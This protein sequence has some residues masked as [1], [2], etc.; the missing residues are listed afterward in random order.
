MTSL[1]ITGNRKSAASRRA[2]VVFP[3]AGA[4]LTIT[5]GGIAVTTPRSRG[6]G[7]LT[8]RPHAGRRRRRPR[9]SDTGETHSTRTDTIWRATFHEVRRGVAVP[10]IWER[11]RSVSCAC[12]LYSFEYIGCFAIKL[13]TIDTARS[14]RMLVA[15]R[16]S[17]TVGSRD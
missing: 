6:G 9:G 4:P 1:A 5:S 13:M 7:G 15:A 14:Q 3:A 11:L 16:D 10:T 17:T 8:P 12:C 2:S